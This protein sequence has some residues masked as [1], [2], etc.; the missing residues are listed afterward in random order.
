MV[1]RTLILIIG[2]RRLQTENN[3]MEEGACQKLVEQV[4]DRID[5]FNRENEFP[6]SMAV[7]HTRT[8]DRNIL[9]AVKTADR[10]M[11]EDK[12]RYK[13]AQKTKA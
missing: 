2:Q 6:L 3:D 8:R 13:D 1:N 7:G 5:C 10:L 11:Y 4:Q 9:E 12:K